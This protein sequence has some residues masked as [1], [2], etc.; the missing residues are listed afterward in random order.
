MLTPAVVLLLVHVAVAVVPAIL[1]LVAVGVVLTPAV[2]VAVGGRVV[3][4]VAVA[5]ATAREAR[6]TVRGAQGYVAARE[7]Q[8][9]DQD[10]QDVDCAIHDRLHSWLTLSLSNFIL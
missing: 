9:Q 7:E 3:L 4:L 5:I 6:P 2:H 10:E 1:V 8:D